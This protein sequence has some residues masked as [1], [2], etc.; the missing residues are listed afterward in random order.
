[1]HA[2]N[3]V[4]Q[5]KSVIDR[6]FESFF[7]LLYF[8]NGYKII[9]AIDWIQN[10][11]T[12]NTKHAI[13]WYVSCFVG[14]GHQKLIIIISLFQTW[15]RMIISIKI[16]IWI[17]ASWIDREWTHLCIN[18]FSFKLRIITHHETE[19]YHLRSHFNAVLNTK[20]S[21][22]W[23]LALGIKTEN[24]IR[25]AKAFHYY[26]FNNCFGKTV[27][28]FSLCLSRRMHIFMVNGSE[29][30]VHTQ[31]TKSPGIQNQ[32]FQ[33]RYWIQL[34]LYR[35]TIFQWNTTLNVS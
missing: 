27:N 11:W 31:H 28:F 13:Q 9:T 14:R 5:N 29:N 19:M 15:K 8:R 17:V 35:M 23:L 3:C 6:I 30:S 21:I 22:I 2:I 33:L 18:F 34:L 12:L 26:L 7:S 32:H 20:Y 25:E 4:A 1:M 10:A 24:N 16:S